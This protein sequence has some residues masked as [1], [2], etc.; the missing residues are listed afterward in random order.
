MTCPHDTAVNTIAS[1]G[2]ID[3]E[4]GYPLH[5]PPAPVV[6]PQITLGTQSKA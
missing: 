4:T 2:D 1:T 5:Q 6:G 3:P